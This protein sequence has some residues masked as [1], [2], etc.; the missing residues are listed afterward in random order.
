MILNKENKHESESIFGREFF[1]SFESFRMI[2]QKKE[3][4]ENN[5]AK[6][7][8][9]WSILMRPASWNTFLQFVIVEQNLIKF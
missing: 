1:H 7:K 5:Q 8:S 6:S 3:R 9:I 2:F 4:E